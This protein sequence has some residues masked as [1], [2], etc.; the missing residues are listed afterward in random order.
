[1][2]E[3]KCLGWGW[4]LSWAY[5]KRGKDG[6]CFSVKTADREK[7][8]EVLNG[9][10]CG[11]SFQFVYFPA[12]CAQKCGQMGESKFHAAD[13]QNQGTEKYNPFSKKPFRNHSKILL[14]FSK[15]RLIRFE[16]IPVEL[17]LYFTF[18]STYRFHFMVLIQKMRP[19]QRP[20]ARI[21][22]SVF[23]MAASKS[24][25]WNILSTF[26]SSCSLRHKLSPPA[27]AL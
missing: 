24:H 4:P 6:L 27:A 16:S 3:L 15:L 7:A 11:N 19:R 8:V 9:K 21:K 22:S 2:E 17:I 1:M 25:N 18:P 12:Q 14:F 5:R 23:F 20:C 10:E 26:I 13:K